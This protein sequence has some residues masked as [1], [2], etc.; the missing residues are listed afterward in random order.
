M[1]WTKK[2]KGM[3][4][5]AYR[6]KKTGDAAS[7]KGPA[8]QVYKSMSKKQLRKALKEPTKKES[9]EKRLEYALGMGNK[10]LEEG[11][12]DLELPEGL[13]IRVEY[14]IDDEPNSIFEA[15]ASQ[16]QHHY[17]IE[18]GSVQDEN[19]LNVE[20]TKAQEKF[21]IEQIESRRSQ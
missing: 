4:G 15:V 10:T 11:Q 18:L 13:S 19:G 2:Q 16:E 3:F 9:F 20:L 8:K 6:A 21:V 12:I 17:E 1:P 5:A 14:E 7:L